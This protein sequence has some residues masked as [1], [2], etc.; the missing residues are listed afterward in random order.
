MTARVDESGVQDVRPGAAVDVLVDASP[1]VPV[2]GRVASVESAASG[3]NQ[4]ETG[5]YVDPLDRERPIYP[6]SDT[7]PRNV[8]RVEQYIPVRIQLTHVGEARIV[9]GMNVTVHIHKQ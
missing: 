5:P 1:G 7:D 4:L 2:T 6:G 9:P 3:V 8:Q